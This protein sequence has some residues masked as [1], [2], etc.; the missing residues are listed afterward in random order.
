M[1]SLVEGRTD[2]LAVV[3]GPGARMA[4]LRAQLDRTSLEV[5]VLPR[6][7]AVAPRRS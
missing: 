7:I 3:D 6:A 4:E 2:R 5:S 1:R